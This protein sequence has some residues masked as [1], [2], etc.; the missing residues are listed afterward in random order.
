MER[1]PRPAVERR[2]RGEPEH[3]RRVVTEQA[4]RDV[5]GQCV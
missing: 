3:R 5:D 1:E 2:R 4:G